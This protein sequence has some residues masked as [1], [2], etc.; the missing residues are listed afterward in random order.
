M[1]SWNKFGELLVIAITIASFPILILNW[2]GGITSG[3]WLAILGE[4]N[5]I[6]FSIALFFV[7]SFAISIALMPSLLLLA[8]VV[9]FLKEGKIT[10]I[11]FGA[12]SLIYTYVVITIWCMW[13]LSTYV[14]MANDHSF[15]PTLIWSYGTALGPWMYMASKEPDN[16]SSSFTV[17]AMAIGYIVA[18]IMTWYGSPFN[19]VVIVFASILG[20]FG[21]IQLISVLPETMRR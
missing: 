4:W 15:L 19:T 16:P 8:P 1:I 10:W 2:L 7:S 14:D 3:I 12:L 11:F 20:I 21:A 5:P 6:L 18:A 17:L 13:I 9:A